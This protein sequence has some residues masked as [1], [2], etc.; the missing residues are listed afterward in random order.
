MV[1]K[2][3]TLEISSENLLPNESIL[4]ASCIEY[5]VYNRAIE[6]TSDARFRRIS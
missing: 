5:N 2:S 4:D 1:V 6:L 3:Y